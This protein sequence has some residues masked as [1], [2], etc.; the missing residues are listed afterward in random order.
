MST[1]RAILGYAFVVSLCLIGLFLIVASMHAFFP[2]H[3]ERSSGLVGLGVL[4]LASGVGMWIIADRIL[5]KL[6]RK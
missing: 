3:I 4:F 2:E 6:R 1:V 5:K